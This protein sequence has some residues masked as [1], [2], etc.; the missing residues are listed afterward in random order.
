MSKKLFTTLC[1][2][3]FVGQALAGEL[4]LPSKFEFITKDTTAGLRQFGSLIVY[5]TQQPADLRPRSNNL[6]ATEQLLLKDYYQKY[7]TGPRT[8]DEQST[9]IDYFVQW[10]D[11]LNQF[12]PATKMI[13]QINIYGG[14]DNYSKT[15]IPKNRRYFGLAADE[16]FELELIGPGLPQY[17]YVWHNLRDTAF[18]EMGHLLYFCAAPTTREL[19]TGYFKELGGTAKY[20]SEYNY[21]AYDTSAFGHAH[22]NDGELYASA[23]VVNMLYYDELTT[24]MALD[25]SRRPELKKFVRLQPV[26][27]QYFVRRFHQLIK[28]LKQQRP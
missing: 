20:W 19:F 11:Y 26:I 23:F 7:E 8:L 25:Y 13:H 4:R 21:L 24:R 16:L 18:H 15:F 2:S 10:V 6:S 1:C 12:L 22:S 27:R 17:S 14:W 5:Y 9:K 3:F 28:N